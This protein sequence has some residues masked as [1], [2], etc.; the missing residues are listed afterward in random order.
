MIKRINFFS[1]VRNVS[2]NIHYNSTGSNFIQVTGSSQLKGS[3]NQ[4]MDYF[5]FHYEWGLEISHIDQSKRD[6]TTKRKID[7]LLG[8]FLSSNWTNRDRIRTDESTSARNRRI[9]WESCK[10]YSFFF[11][12]AK[13]QNFTWVRILLRGILEIKNCWRKNKSNILFFP[14]NRKIK[15]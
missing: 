2:S 1:K 10:S 9:S 12:L 13:G 5:Q 8:S 11:F 6:S 3:S 14:S 7:S 15:K 4:S